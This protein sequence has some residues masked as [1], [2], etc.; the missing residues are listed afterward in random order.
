MSPILL[1]IK[2]SLFATLI[3]LILCLPFAYLLARVSFPGRRLLYMLT[4]LPLVLPP[5]VL[6]FYLLIAFSPNRAL[7]AFMK[8]QG[9]PLVFS[10]T[11]L[12]IASVIYSL[13]FMLNALTTAIKALPG[14][15]FERAFLL[16]KSFF[17]KLFRLILPRITP[18]IVSGCVL[19]YAHTMGEFG[20]VMMIGGSKLGE[21][22]VASIAI[23]EAI[24]TLDYAAAHE[25][26]VI[27]LAISLAVLMTVSFL[28]RN[29]G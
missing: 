20:V 12:L 10:F 5:T 16:D 14:S 9:W 21:T 24:E 29:K 6:G 8:E 15:L 7:G 23:F 26:S 18:A 1:S 27:L 2:L 4:N 11:G 28:E 17:Y 3:L 13:P 22:K 19:S 25:Y